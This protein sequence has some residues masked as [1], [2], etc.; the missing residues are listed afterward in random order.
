MALLKL[1]PNCQVMRPS[2]IG[3]SHGLPG[4]R[5]GAAACRTNSNHGN[6]NE[7]K[8]RSQ[9]CP[10]MAGFLTSKMLMCFFLRA[11]CFFWGEGL[12]T[13][14][15]WETRKRK[16]Q[17]HFFF[18]FQPRPIICFLFTWREAQAIQEN[19]K[20]NRIWG[21][22]G[23]TPIV[24]Q[25]S[26]TLQTF[27]ENFLQ[28]RGCPGTWHGHATLHLGMNTF[29]WLPFGKLTQQW[30]M[31]PLKMY[32]LLKMEIFHCYVSLLDGSFQIYTPRR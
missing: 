11:L 21:C 9:W 4:K 14:M 30:E 6:S 28:E 13:R 12:L 32:F 25:P 18:T 26:L 17:R 27:S 19:T 31:D 5:L 23:E 16:V 3:T 29:R 7:S 2:I 10:V 22:C 15:S 24:A 8:K 20:K 1:W